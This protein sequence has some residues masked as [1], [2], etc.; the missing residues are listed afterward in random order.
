MPPAHATLDAQRVLRWRLFFALT[1]LVV[2]SFT[3]YF[4]VFF[5][6]QL[7]T[8]FRENV[9][10]ST[11]RQRRRQ[12][13]PLLLLLM[14]ANEKETYRIDKKGAAH[15]EVMKYSDE[16]ICYVTGMLLLTFLQFFHFF[17]FSFFGAMCLPRCAHTVQFGMT[18]CVNG[19]N[20][21]DT[22][23]NLQNNERKKASATRACILD[24]LTILGSKKKE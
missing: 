13:L 15:D 8:L 11:I 23:Y 4:F 21:A 18:T 7:D 19:Y 10:E 14:V 20:Y 2:V 1:L 6:T 3:F 24:A 9:K 17:Y 5:F 22:I 16:F 12:Q